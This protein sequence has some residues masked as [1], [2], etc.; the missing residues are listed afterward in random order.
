MQ[1]PIS[2]REESGIL[3]TTHRNEQTQKLYER[4]ELS[5]KTKEAYQTLENGSSKRPG[6]NQGKLKAVA[7]LSWEKRE[8]VSNMVGGYGLTNRERVEAV[9]IAIHKLK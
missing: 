3:V 7:F 9:A 4:Y 5:P 1:S 2:P 6:H 8:A